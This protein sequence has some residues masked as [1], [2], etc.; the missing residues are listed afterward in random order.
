MTRLRIPAAS[1]EAIRRQAKKTRPEECCGILLGKEGERGRRV[2]E[3]IPAGNAATDRRTGYA[4]EPRDLFAAGKRARAEGL[5]IV[6]YY[7]S[8]P[9]GGARPSPRDAEHAWPGASYVIL[10]LGGGE[11]LRS[12]RLA[13]GAGEFEEEAVEIMEASDEAD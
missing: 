3:A 2:T 11:E 6:G 8:H 9:G 4:I 5:E 1:L 12:W 13:S 10:G 7:H